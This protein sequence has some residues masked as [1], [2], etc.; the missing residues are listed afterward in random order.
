MPRQLRLS[1]LP[2]LIAGICTCVG[3]S[4]L[5]AIELARMEVNAPYQAFLPAIV[6]CCLLYGFGGAIIAVLLSAL[7]LWY[8]FIP[9]GGFTLPD[10]AH[11]GHLLIFLGVAMFVCR[12]ITRQRQANDQL[13]QE[14]FE[15][16]YKVFLMRE[17]R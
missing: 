9:P 10:Y 12:I 13:V 14:N 8:F 7:S 11:A 16:G 2:F 3:L 6:L 15:L 1:D 5:L 4:A 17:I